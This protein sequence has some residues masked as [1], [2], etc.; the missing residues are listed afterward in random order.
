[1]IAYKNKYNEQAL[2]K[3]LDGLKSS[4]HGQSSGSTISP[5]PGICALGYHT[6]QMHKDQVIPHQDPSDIANISHPM[7]KLALCIIS[8]IESTSNNLKS[9]FLNRRYITAST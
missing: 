7:C 9:L 2:H 4:S 5:V 6:C 1:M 8:T 3:N